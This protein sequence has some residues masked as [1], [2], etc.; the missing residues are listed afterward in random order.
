LLEVWRAFA[1]PDFALALD[2]GGPSDLLSERPF[3][4]QHAI[5]WLRCE[6]SVPQR[7]EHK[8]LA[9]LW[10]GAEAVAKRASREKILA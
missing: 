1:G 8:F 6:A 7:Q 9:L 2:V 4:E 3:D 5:C 10:L